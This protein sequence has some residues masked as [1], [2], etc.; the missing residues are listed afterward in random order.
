MLSIGIELYLDLQGI[1][2]RIEP[3]RPKTSSPTKR[4]SFFACN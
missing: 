1:P 3:D 2:G 4:S